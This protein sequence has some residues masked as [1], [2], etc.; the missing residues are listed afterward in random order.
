MEFHP[1]HRFAGFAAAVLFDANYRLRRWDQMERW[2]RYM[3]DRKN[4]KVLSKETEGRHR[5]F[6][7]RIRAG[8][9]QKGEK[10][11]AADQYLRFVNEFPKNDKAPA[12]LS[13]LWR[14]RRNW[15]DRARR[16]PVPVAHAE[17]LEDEASHRRS[18]AFRLPIPAP[19][20]V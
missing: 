16:Q 7:Q 11:K 15:K 14:S 13:L 8:A 9:T 20:A 4:Y 1:T 3:L 12:S 6:H 10:Q 17:I 5:G 2:A 18:L 19:N